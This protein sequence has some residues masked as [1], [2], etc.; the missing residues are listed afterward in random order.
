MKQKATGQNSW[1]LRGVWWKSNSDCAC[2]GFRVLVVF[3]QFPA[4]LPSFV[5]VQFQLVWGGF[6]T[7]FVLSVM[8]LFLRFMNF[9][10]VSL[11]LSVFC[12]LLIAANIFISLLYS[13]ISTSLCEWLVTPRTGRKS[14]TGLFTQQS[15]V[16]NVHFSLSLPRSTCSVYRSVVYLNVCF[17]FFV[18]IFWIASE[19]ESREHIWLMTNKRCFKQHKSVTGRIQCCHLNRIAITVIN[20]LAFVFLY[21]HKLSCILMLHK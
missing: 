21:I 4:W 5:S 9:S 13:P 16:N 7:I 10:L 11:C 3:V 12:N 1:K 18:K 15:P 8:L 6:V 2:H 20:W 19:S 14:I 17:F